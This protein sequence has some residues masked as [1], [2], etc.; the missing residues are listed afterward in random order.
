MQKSTCVESHFRRSSRFCS[1]RDCKTIDLRESSSWS[2]YS[3]L[4]LFHL[5]VLTFLHY[6]YFS[7]SSLLIVFHFLYSPFFVIVLSFYLFKCFLFLWEYLQRD[8][9]KSYAF[10]LEI[11]K[12]DRKSYTFIALINWFPIFFLFVIYINKKLC[13]FRYEQKILKKWSTFT[14]LW[15]TSYL[16]SVVFLLFASIVNQIYDQGDIQNHVFLSNNGNLYNV[17]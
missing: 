17:M 10:F 6:L 5:F 2:V 4:E 3:F 15:M 14:H 7:F 13:T 16:C 1:C 12:K 9:Q 8:G 11:Q